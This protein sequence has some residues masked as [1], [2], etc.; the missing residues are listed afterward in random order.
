MFSTNPLKH[1]ASAVRR[2]GAYRDHSIVPPSFPTGTTVM[3]RCRTAV[4]FDNIGP[5]HRARLEAAADICEL[6][7][8]EFGKSNGE[9]SWRSD[10][11]RRFRCVTINTQGESHALPGPVF[12]E[13][14]A[15]AL[16]HFDAE[17]VFLPGW[18]CRGAIF[19][20]DWCQR[21]GKPAVVMSE[22][23]FL[24]APRR[25]ARESVKRGFLRLA[26]A[27]LAGGT[28]QKEYLIQLGME[29]GHISMGYDAVDNEYFAKGAANVRSAER[30]EKERVSGPDFGGQKTT[31]AAPALLSRFRAVH[32][33]EESAKADRGLCSI[34]K[35]GTKQRA[36]SRETGPGI[37]N[38]R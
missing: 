7:A 9:Y 34:Q 3:Q 15:R 29:A 8:V 20:M 5:Y 36:R 13:R 22:S 25:L 26:A 12:R 10:E 2:T 32:R 17:V 27:A 4:L 1:K 33:K 21:N 35:L 38:A 28:P 6:L 14:L 16:K 11:G 30:G 23:T 18:S 31:P 37:G 24:D 19:G